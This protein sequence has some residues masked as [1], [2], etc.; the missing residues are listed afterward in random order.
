MLTEDRR[1]SSNSETIVKV[2]SK[3]KEVIDAIID[4]LK[5]VFTCEVTSPKMYNDEKDVF[6]QFVEVQR[7]V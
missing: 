1:E 5:I 2:T 6:F 3:N 7:R 4:H